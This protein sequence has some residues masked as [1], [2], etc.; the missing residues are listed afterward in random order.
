MIQRAL[1]T[2]KNI[3]YNSA[4]TQYVIKS[5]YSVGDIGG[6]LDVLYINRKMGKYNIY[7]ETNRGRQIG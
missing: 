2:F 4:L 3:N 1:T 6:I 5:G 7:L